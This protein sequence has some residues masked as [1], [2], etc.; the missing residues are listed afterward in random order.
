MDRTS[1]MP[2]IAARYAL[3]ALAALVDATAPLSSQEKQ[4]QAP[5]D[6][7]SFESVKA[8]SNPQMA[9]SGST[10]L[11]TVRT[12]NLATNSRASLT[13]KVAASGGIA[14]AFPDAS[15]NA[16]EARWSPDG[17]RVAYIAGNQL[18]VADLTGASRKQLTT[19]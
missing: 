18:W 1:E 4:Q 17:K 2:N 12:T 13:Y 7:N 19:L 9:P 16:T 14:T 10:V 6:I 5:V 8:V 11:Y 15:T 3:S